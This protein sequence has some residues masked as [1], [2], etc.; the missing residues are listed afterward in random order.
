M[1]CLSPDE[2][3]TG[4]PISYNRQVRHQILIYL[5]SLSSMS[6]QYYPHMQQQQVYVRMVMIIFIY[7][8]LA[9]VD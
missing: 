7:M 1:L 9:L 6:Q 3:V 4:F 2:H 5:I 8:M